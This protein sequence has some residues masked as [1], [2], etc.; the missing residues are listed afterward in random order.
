MIKYFATYN[1]KRIGVFESLKKA[2]QGIANHPE[3]FKSKYTKKGTP[4]SNYPELKRFA[5]SDN[6]GQLYYIY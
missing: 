6:N 2:Q 3:F 5:I 4:K 1:F